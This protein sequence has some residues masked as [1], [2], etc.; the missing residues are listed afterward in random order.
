MVIVDSH[1]H[2]SELF[3]EPVELL[4]HQ[5]QR[6][7]VQH[8]ILIQI[9]GQYDNSYQEECIRQF[10]GKLSSVVLVD[11]NGD[12]A[13]AALEQCVERGA[14]GV[15]L[16]MDDPEVVWRQAAKLS[17][18]VSAQAGAAAFASEKFTRLVEELPDMPIVM[19]HYAGL[20]RIGDGTSGGD[21]VVSKVLGLARYPNVYIKVHGLGEFAQRAVPM[22]PD[23]PFVRPVPDVLDRVAAAF[24]PDKMMWGSDYPPC[25]MREGYRN[26]LRLPM[27]VLEK[28]YSPDDLAKISGGNAL[29]VFPIS[30]VR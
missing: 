18:A 26:A 24:G 10:P 17:I 9:G 11:V 19:E 5:M 8:A 15:R 6:N 1:C 12:N 14:V 30:E 28:R 21:E 2:A 22:K 4:V 23:F 13:P 25:S 29:K 16:R 3:F 27:R 20:H 7:G